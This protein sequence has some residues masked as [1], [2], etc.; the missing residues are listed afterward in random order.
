MD[1]FRNICSKEKATESYL[2]YLTA[3]NQ[4]ILFCSKNGKNYLATKDVDPELQKLRI[5]VSDTRNSIYS[6]RFKWFYKRQ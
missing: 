1:N 4:K 2:E 3:L 6:L 5:K